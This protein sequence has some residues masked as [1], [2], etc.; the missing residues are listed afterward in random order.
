MFKKIESGIKLMFQK[1]WIRKQY[2]PSS[3]FIKVELKIYPNK[4]HDTEIDIGKS[5]NAYV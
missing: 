1:D 2:K 3:S 4:F 5:K